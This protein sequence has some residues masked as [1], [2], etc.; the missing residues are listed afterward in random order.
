MMKSRL[1]KLFLLALAFGLALSMSARPANEDDQGKECR[2]PENNA[3]TPLE[4][5]GVVPLPGAALNS[6]D[7]AFVDPGTERFYLADRSNNGVDI[8]DAENDTF[9]GRVVGFAGTPGTNGPGPNGVLVT[10]NRIL[11]A[12][13]GNAT[14]QA[15]DVD[16]ASPDYLTIIKSV[17][18]ANGPC[19]TAVPNTCNRA[20]EVGYD[21]KDHKVLAAV[22]APTSGDKSATPYAALIDA[23]TY[24]TVFVTIPNITTTANGGGL[25]QPLWDGELGVFFL[26]VPSVGPA[27]GSGEIAVINPKTGVVKKAYPTPG[28]SPTGEVLAPF[29]RLVVNCGN[30]AA[31]PPVNQLLIL[32]ATNG[33]LITTVPG[34]SSDELWFN[35][36]DDLVYATS[37]PNLWAVDPQSGTVFQTINDPGGRNMAAFAENNHVFTPVRAAAGDQCTKYGVGTAAAPVGCVAV[38]AHHETEGGEE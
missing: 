4:A 3:K 26:T 9:A 6:S 25:E 15:A 17:N 31:V 33:H 8:I 24:A 20:D 7:I 18:V 14:V 29:Q 32:N 1:F 37:T 35:P 5:I 16:P 22:N 23:N 27:S 2:Q 28:C 10:P 30:S 21:P 36:G 13:D 38:F 11:F 34:V 19:N 12:G